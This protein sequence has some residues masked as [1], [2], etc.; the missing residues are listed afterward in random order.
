[1]QLTKPKPTLQS[2]HYLISLLI[3]VICGFIFI[4]AAYNAFATV[5]E[6]PGMRGSMHVYYGLS[7]WQF[8]AYYLAVCAGALSI[9]IMTIIYLFTDDVRKL[10]RAFIWFLVFIALLIGCELHLDSMWIGKG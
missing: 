2:H 5:S 6:K 3:L 7:I 4:G 8:A 1:M 10:N 9:V